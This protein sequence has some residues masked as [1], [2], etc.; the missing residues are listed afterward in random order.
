MKKL[1][2]IT[3][4]LMVAVMAFS[5]IR[6]VEFGCSISEVEKTEKEA[7]FYKSYST[8]NGTLKALAYGDVK[9][10]GI[11]AQVHYFFFEN[12]LMSVSYLFVDD[13]TDGLDYVRDFYSITE[14]LVEKYGEPEVW[15]V[16]WDDDK[17]DEDYKYSGVALMAGDIQFSFEWKEGSMAIE[18]SLYKDAGEIL[19]GL[20]YVYMPL[21]EKQLE[22]EKELKQEKD[23]G[24]F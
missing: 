24:N 22:K 14:A 4:I 19:H 12:K 16:L 17:Y 2:M 11:E 21:R 9:L 7:T 3:V 5:A 18:L 20:S 6:G 23:K 15:D 13:Y 1:A 10:L 8:Y